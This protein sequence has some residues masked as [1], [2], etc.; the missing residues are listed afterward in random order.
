MRI[1]ISLDGL[2]TIYA[3]DQQTPMAQHALASTLHA[4][5]REWITVADHHSDLWS[6]ALG[7]SLG[8]ER[9]ALDVYQ[10]VLE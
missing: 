3:Q 10:E 4:T 7:A 1:R 5:P 8:V 6:K 9:R 2:L